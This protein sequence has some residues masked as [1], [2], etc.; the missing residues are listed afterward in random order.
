MIHPHKLAVTCMIL[1][2]EENI[3]FSSSCD[4]SIAISNFD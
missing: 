1:N 3:I 2:E 4:G